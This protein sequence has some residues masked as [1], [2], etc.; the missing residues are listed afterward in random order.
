M[1]SPLW[2][3]GGSDTTAVA[4]AAALNAEKCE[5]F[6]DVEGVYSADPRL[7]P[8]ARKLDEVDYS[9]GMLELAS[10]GAM[11]PAAQGS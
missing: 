3:G 10:L 7:V 8:D 9:R 2:V 5:I 11:I 4:V 1:I 6:T